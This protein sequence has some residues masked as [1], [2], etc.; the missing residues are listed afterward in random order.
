MTRLF[1]LCYLSGW[2]RPSA[3]PRPGTQWTKVSC[4]KNASG[5]LRSLCDQLAFPSPCSSQP[6][7]SSRK[8]AHSRSLRPRPPSPPTCPPPQRLPS[9]RRFTAS[10]SPPSTRPP[11][12][13]WT[14]TNTPAATGRRTTRFPSDQVRWGRFNELIER[15]NYLLYT[16]LE[17]ASKP[18]A[19]RTPLQKQY[20]DFFAACMNTTLT[21]EKGAKPI[22]P[23]LQQVAALEDKNATRRAG[24]ATSEEPARHRLLRH[25]LATGPQR[26]HENDRRHPARRLSLPDRDYYLE[27]DD[28]MTKIRQQYTDYMVDRLQARRRFS[29]A[30]RDRGEK[31]PR[32]R[33]RAGQGID[34]AA[35]NFATR[36]SVYHPMESRRSKAL[37]PDFDWKSVLHLHRRGASS[38]T[39]TSACPTSSRRWTRSSPPAAC[40]S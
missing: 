2:E 23:N 18:S 13:A 31:R 37:A 17:K 33:D 15:N 19:D 29:R 1:R 3:A 27:T 20:G 38:P 11:T 9:L 16:Q 24:R 10:I 39:S 21:N 32:H 6:E 14:S 28:R 36:R 25:R 5:I 34:P 7:S 8:P 12:P 26:L 35:P 40:R 30:G 22:E 4:P